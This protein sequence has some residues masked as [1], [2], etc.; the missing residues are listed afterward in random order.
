MSVVSI[1]IDE[2]TKKELENLKKLKGY[3]SL[4]EI[5][6]EA[7]REYIL[8]SKSFWRSR[9]EVY[10]YFRNRNKKARGLED[11]HLEEEL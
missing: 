3:K 11:L 8:R 2:E 10:N 1:R 9:E 5:I 4:N 6:N 7:I